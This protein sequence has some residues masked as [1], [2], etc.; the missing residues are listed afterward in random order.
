MRA[1]RR[2][3]ETHAVTDGGGQL[4]LCDRLTAFLGR[5]TPI[6]LLLVAGACAVSEAPPIRIILVT[7]DTLRADHLESYGYPRGVSPFLDGLAD[8]SVVFDQ[9]FAS[10]PL[11]AP[12]HASLFTSLQPAQHRLLV[13][14]EVLDD[15]L[16]TIAQ[17]LS[18]QGYRTAAF[19]PVKFLNGL[20]AGFDHFDSSEAYEPA[21]AVLARAFEW[22]EETGVDEKSFVWVHLYDVHEWFRPKHL[23]R[24]AVRWVIENAE[25][26]GGRLR[27]WLG[28]HHG[29]PADLPEWKVS[30]MTAINRYDGQLYAVDR[31]LESFYGKLGAGDLLD[32]SIWFITSDHGEGL[33][34][35]SRMGH[36]HYLYD[37]QIRV[38]LLVHSPTGRLKTGRVSSIVRLVDLAPTIADLTG[39]SMETQVI[40]IVGRSTVP[41][42]HGR[43]AQ[44]KATE[45]FSQRRPA[46]NKLLR[47]GWLPGE[48]YATRSIDRKLIINTE[49][50]C[51]YY[52]LG[53]DPFE[54]NNLCDPSEP[55]VA[56]LI[57]RLTGAFAAMRSQGES[58]HSGAA[59]PE[60]IDELKALGYL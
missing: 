35:H 45:A 8:R 11:T 6:L 3:A 58:M 9:V 17:L 47:E 33:G 19:T 57:R 23:R 4:L 39:S 31:A 38:P 56:E 46:N 12:S 41:L 24:E 32:G 13:N 60:I 10:C 50:S 37:E 22:L 18:Q 26:K 43:L 29:L 2:C 34:N 54:V 14:G 59:A 49:G 25:L 52:H 5:A 48:V 36:G 55:D 28:E 20:A 30:I 40:P 53:V 7:I 51:E 1:L 27:S 44:W 16:L 42:L 21:E 15:Q